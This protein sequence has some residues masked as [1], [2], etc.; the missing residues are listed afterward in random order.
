MCCYVVIEVF[1][2]QYVVAGYPLITRM[3]A[4]WPWS[5]DFTPDEYDLLCSEI[6]YLQCMIIR[7][8]PPVCHPP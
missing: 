2:V 3:C 6:R 7:F 4:Y 1:L 8:F 5:K